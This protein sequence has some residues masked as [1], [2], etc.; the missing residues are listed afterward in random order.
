ME[1]GVGYFPTHDG[2]SPGEV[3]R[4]VE[5]RGQNALF[6]AE[7]SHIPASRESPTRAVRCRP[8]TGTATTCSWR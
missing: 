6:F 3:A 2:M 5:D 4:L 8:S 7:H 1:F